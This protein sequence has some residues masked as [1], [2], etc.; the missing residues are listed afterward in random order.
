MRKLNDNR[1]I[2]RLLLVVTAFESAVLVVAGIG[3]LVAPGVLRPMWPWALAPFNTMLLGAIYSSS[4]VAT[5]MVVYVKRWA[6]TRVVLPMIL[7]F[8]AIVLIVCLVYIDRFDFQRWE[9][10]LWFLLYII[11]PANAAYHV[12]LYRNLKPF[13]PFPLPVPWRG[14]LLIPT[15]LLGLY[16]IGLLIAPDKFSSFWPWPIDDFHGRVYSVLFITPATGALLLYGAAASIELLTAGLTQFV[17]AGIAIVGLVVID[18]Q[19]DKIDWS[20]SGTW[21]W[22]G[23]F[24]I[25]LLTGA[26][27]IWQ[28][29]VRS[30]SEVFSAAADSAQV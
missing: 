25:I 9:T 24:V 20:A 30:R 8:T 12:W 18:N 5:A 19:V 29:R 21:M 23:S 4:L 16:G 10:W 28:S 11:I 26:G 7:I 14:V 15:I 17:G 6:P 1:E 22:I 13:N 27:L 2:T 3:L